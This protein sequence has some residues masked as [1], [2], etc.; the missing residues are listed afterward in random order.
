MSPL[1]TGLPSWDSKSTAKASKVRIL[2]RHHVFGKPLTSGNVGQGLILI[3]VVGIQMSVGESV[4]PATE[5]T[6]PNVSS[7]PTM[8]SRAAIPGS[9]V[10]FG[11]MLT[12]LTNMLT[13]LR[14]Y[15]A[16]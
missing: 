10:R 8:D 13:A 6:S 1:V 16:G 12:S 14:V 15:Q 4:I 9:P 7:A 3:P 11:W 5:A 2:H